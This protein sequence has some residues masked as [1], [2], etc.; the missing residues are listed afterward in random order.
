VAEELTHLK[1]K[2]SAPAK[3]GKVCNLADIPAVYLV[4]ATA[5]IWTDTMGERTAG[6]YM[7]SIWQNLHVP[8]AESC[9][10]IQGRNFEAVVI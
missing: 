4:A 1:M 6:V 10:R 8:Y 9:I 3:Y 5:A 2:N 7:D